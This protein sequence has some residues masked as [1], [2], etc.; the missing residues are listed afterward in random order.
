MDFYTK[1][2]LAM[3]FAMLFF[4][5]LSRRKKRK[6]NRP[7]EIVPPELHTAQ[8]LEKPTMTFGDIAN[9][10]EETKKHSWKVAQKDVSTSELKNPSLLLEKKKV[11]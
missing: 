8:Q 7:A 9:E 1:T 2:L 4:L 10:I 11:K 5:L 3:F 6:S